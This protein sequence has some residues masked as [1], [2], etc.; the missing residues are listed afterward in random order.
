[1]SRK[2]MTE[3]RAW[4]KLAERF[5]THCGYICPTLQDWGEGR[6]DDWNGL[7]S[8]VEAGT[9]RRMRRRVSRHTKIA[10]GGYIQRLTDFGSPRNAHARVIF[11]LL[12]ALECEEEA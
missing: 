3:A 9:A 10:E 8:I 4:R 2:P 6:T 7:P 1:M 12:M 11:C 5:A